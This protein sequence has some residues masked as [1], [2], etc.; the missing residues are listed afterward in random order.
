MA[1]AARLWA[2]AQTARWLFSHGSHAL[3]V[4]PLLAIG[5]TSPKWFRFS[6]WHQ[7]GYFR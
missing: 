2:S 7:K 4:R 5:M 3:P 6:R 1:E